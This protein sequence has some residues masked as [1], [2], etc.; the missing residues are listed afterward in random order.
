M[1]MVDKFILLDHVQFEKNGYQNRYLING[2]WITKPVKSSLE[3]I[4][5]KEYVDGKKLAEHNERWIRLLADEMNITTEIIKD[6]DMETTSTQ[7]LIDIVKLHGG[8]TYVTNP[9]A[10]DKY[11]DEDLIKSQGIKIKYCKVPLHL[12]KHTFAIFEKYGIDGAIKQL[13]KR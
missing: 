9:E 8:D 5:D 6:I 3:L 13:P 7:R 10:K 4:V 12:Q 1:A 2:K 11:L